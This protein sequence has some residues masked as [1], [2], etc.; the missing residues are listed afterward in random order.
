MT[1]QTTPAPVATQDYVRAEVNAMEGKLERALREISA[2]L[3]RRTDQISAEMNARTLEMGRRTE[4]LE[5]AL[6]T[7]T[8]WIIGIGFAVT[9]AVLVRPL[10]G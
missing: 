6:R 7:Q 4:R 1:D 5:D 10:L 8:R 3:N 2:D 9:V